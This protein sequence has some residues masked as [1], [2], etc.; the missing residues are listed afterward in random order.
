MIDQTEILNR[1]LIQCQKLK[2]VH[3]KKA[4]KYNN[5]YNILTSCGIIAG[6]ITATITGLT[7]YMEEPN[8]VLSFSSIIISIFSSIIM[9]SIK[10]IKFEEIISTHKLASSNYSNLENNIR[11]HD[12][13]ND[14]LTDN[15]SYIKNI[16]DS[17]NKIKLEAPLLSDDMY[18]DEIHE[19]E[20]IVV[21]NPN[22]NWDEDNK[23]LDYEL[24]R[25]PT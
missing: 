7:N 21:I 15:I 25:L 8:T 22:D 16:Q 24:S 20:E 4:N 18:Y 23:I 10:I 2:H 3:L 11:I 5:I 9:S 14:E 1:L 12:L 17:F 6:P 19:Q 13:E